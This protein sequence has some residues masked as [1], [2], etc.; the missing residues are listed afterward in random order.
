MNEIRKKKLESQIQREVALLIIQQKL[1]AEVG[2]VSVTRVDL[3]ADLSGCRVYLSFFGTDT[4]NH[5]SLSVLQ[6]ARHF[7]QS[8]VS[9]KLRLRQTPQFAFEVD[10]SIEE[11][12]RILEIIEKDRT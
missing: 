8:S 3:A 7:I 10:R 12:D 6:G 11:G 4:E 9:R 2:F 5:R 1:K